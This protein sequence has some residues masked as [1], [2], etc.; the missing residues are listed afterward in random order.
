MGALQNF[1]NYRVRVWKC[2]TELTQKFRAGTKKAVPVPG[3]CGKGR[4][5]LKEVPGKGMDVI[6]NLS[7]IHI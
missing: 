4:T 5:E 7:L 2:V 1:Q 3:Y 6:Q